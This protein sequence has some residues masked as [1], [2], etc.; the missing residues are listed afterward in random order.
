[1]SSDILYKRLCVFQAPNRALHIEIKMKKIYK[2]FFKDNLYCIDGEGEKTF[3]ATGFGLFVYPAILPDAANDCGL[4]YV[5][6]PEGRGF[7]INFD[8]VRSIHRI[9]LSRNIDGSEG[10]AIEGLPK[11]VNAKRRD[12]FDLSLSDIPLID[13]GSCVVFHQ[14]YLLFLPASPQEVQ[15][16][17]RTSL[18]L[19]PRSPRYRGPNSSFEL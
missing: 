4:N 10:I 15:A 9:R 17:Q 18:D 2:D 1:M 3:C 14:H 11:H 5:F 13:G 12:Y 7:A 6:W 8:N 16:L 19:R